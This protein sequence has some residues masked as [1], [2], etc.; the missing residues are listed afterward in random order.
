MPKL[1]K[2]TSDAKNSSDLQEVDLS[3]LVVFRPTVV[4]FPGQFA[5]DDNP[6]HISLEIKHAKDVFS[7][8]PEQ[9]EI[10]LWSNPDDGTRKRSFAR[11][12]LRSAFYNA[13]ACRTALYSADKLAKGMIL[14]LATD[15]Q[16]KPLP[17]AEAQKNLRNL[18][19]FGY[20]I[21][22][23]AAQEVYNAARKMLR[24]AGYSRKDTRLLL[25]EIVLVSVASASEPAKERHRYTNVTLLYNDDK[26]I[27]VKD[28]IV[29]PLHT[30]TKSFFKASQ[31]L[32]IRRLSDTSLL[33]T[34]AALGRKRD[35]KKETP[36]EVIEGVQLP[37]WNKKA[38]NHFTP[39]Y[40]NSNDNSCQ[41]SRIAEHALVNAVNRKGTV[42]PVDLLTAPPALEAK[43]RELYQRRIQQAL[44]T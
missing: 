20:C 5:S 19:F 16:G 40:I 41:F 34:A 38:T 42:K 11:T 25:R 31:K 24:K 4:F 39:D 3:K 28:W 26:G 43:T 1:W 14:P 23:L 35:R 17:L 21:G 7:N 13:T 29:S 6:Y 8:Q 22:N 12:F 36:S 37:R 30:L 44:H 32:A 10:Y 33:I 2:K 27:R 18:T 9:P 15:A